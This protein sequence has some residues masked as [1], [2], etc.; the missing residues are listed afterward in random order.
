MYY[1]FVH[2]LKSALPTIILQGTIIHEM[3][4]FTIT[5]D[6][7]DAAY[8]QA[9]CKALAI[10]NP[11]NAVN[12]ADSHEYAAENTPVLSCG[13]SLSKPSTVKPTTSKPST[14]LPTPL[15]PTSNPSPVYLSA[16]VQL[17]RWQTQLTVQQLHFPPQQCQPR[18]SPR[19]EQ[20]PLAMLRPKAVSHKICAAVWL[21]IVVAVG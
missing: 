13:A 11:G 5:A 20:L 9:D 4:H 14:S 7:D 19:L 8:G 16:Q 18:Q 6:T 10:S 3:T 12:N 2:R 17:L 21:A 1:I 15:K